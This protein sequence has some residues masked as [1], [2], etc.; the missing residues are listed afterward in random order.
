MRR[1]QPHHHHNSSIYLSIYDAFNVVWIIIVFLNTLINEV[2]SSETFYSFTQI[3]T[4]LLKKNRFLLHIFY[5]T[6]VVLL[7]SLFLSV[8]DKEVDQSKLIYM[9]GIQR[10]DIWN[11]QRVLRKQQGC[12]T[13]RG[14][15]HC[16]EN[17]PEA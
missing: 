8:K 15:F 17:R 12:D 4:L 11:V 10:L 3:N 14:T 16:T 9:Y 6:L 13:F 1:I 5:F 2:S 7:P